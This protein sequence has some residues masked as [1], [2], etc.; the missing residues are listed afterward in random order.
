MAAYDGNCAVVPWAQR[1]VLAKLAN[2]NP[3]VVYGLVLFP[4]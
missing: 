1:V 4:M 2:E 3:W